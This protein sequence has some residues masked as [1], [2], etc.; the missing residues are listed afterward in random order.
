SSG[1]ISSV[2][3]QYPANLAP[4]AE[5]F[6]DC[7]AGTLP[8]VSLVDPEFGVLGEV[9]GPLAS[10]NI[11]GAAKAGGLVGAQGGARRTRRTS[12]S[13]RPRRRG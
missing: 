2:P 11:P 12:R 1:I 10:L 9:G 4:I 13:A 7:A 3:K 8:A 5:F 6:S